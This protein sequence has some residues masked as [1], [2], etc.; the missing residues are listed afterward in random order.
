MSFVGSSQYSTIA[1][2]IQYYIVLFP[3]LDVSSAFPLNAI[4]LGNNLFISFNK[5]N[6]L[7]SNYLVNNEAYLLYRLLASIPPFLFAIFLN[8][9]SQITSYTGVTGFLITMLFPACLAWSSKRYMH[10]KGLKYHTAYSGIFT[11]EFC[12]LILFIMS[13]LFTILVLFSFF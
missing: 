7:G 12:I 3:A 9:L 13:I 10:S 5:Y 2:I 11:S 1:I 6:F 8:N 4:T